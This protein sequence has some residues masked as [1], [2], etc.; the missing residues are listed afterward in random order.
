MIEVRVSSFPGNPLMK[1][2][3]V[4]CPHCEHVWSY[5]YECPVRCPNCKAKM[6]NVS[7]LIRS[8]AE[9]VFFHKT[10]ETA[11]NNRKLE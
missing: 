5:F 3:T 4:R 1:Q 2:A 8:E 9:R 7:S 11:D 10:C 6:P